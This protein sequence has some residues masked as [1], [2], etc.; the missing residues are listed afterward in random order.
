MKKL[1]KDSP[2]GGG[3][4]GGGEVMRYD[5]DWTPIF[6]TKDCFPDSLPLKKNRLFGSALGR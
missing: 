3:G 6:A 4:G 2:G 5:R 1:A